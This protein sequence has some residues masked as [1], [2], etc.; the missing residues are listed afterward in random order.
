MTQQQSK[1]QPPN[2]AK[3]TEQQIADLP[4]QDMIAYIQWLQSEKSKAEQ[5]ASEAE[6]R[7]QRRKI[8]WSQFPDQW[9]LIGNFALYS[10]PKHFEDGKS[11]NG[12]GFVLHLY[13]AYPSRNKIYSDLSIGAYTRNDANHQLAYRLLSAGGL[14]ATD[15]GNIVESGLLQPC[16]SSWKAPILDTTQ[17]EPPL[18]IFRLP[19]PIAVDCKRRT[20]TK[21]KTNPQTGEMYTIDVYQYKIL[22]YEQQFVK[23]SWEQ[24]PMHKGFYDNLNNK[25]LG[26]WLKKQN[27]ST[28]NDAD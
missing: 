16:E 1:A 23:C 21:E 8:D 2:F 18:T 26:D 20:K 13:D 11:K 19:F 28:T 4:Q 27:E 9:K 3:L 17:P 24:L 15:L 10:N 22:Y 5:R 7:P 6:S 12:Q 25:R 14:S